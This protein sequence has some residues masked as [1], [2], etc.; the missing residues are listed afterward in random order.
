MN[1]NVAEPVIMIIPHSLGKE[2]AMR[3]LKSGLATANL[4]FLTIDREFWNN[5]L[6]EFSV[7]AMGQTASGSALV[8]SDGVRLTLILPWLLQRF[9]KLAGG[10]LASRTKLLLDKK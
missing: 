7:S 4:P 9:A 8:M 2:E 3:R 5:D 10:T 1:E 6:L